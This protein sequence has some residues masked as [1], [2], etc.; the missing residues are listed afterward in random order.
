MKRWWPPGA[1]RWPRR[2]KEELGGSLPAPIGTGAG[3]RTAARPSGHPSCRRTS[4]RPQRAASCGSCVTS[5]SVAPCSRCRSNIRSITF[6]RG[7]VQAAGRLIGEQQVRVHH[8]AP[9]TRAAARRPTCAG[10]GAG[11]RPA[12]PARAWPGR[13]RA[14]W[15]ANSSGSMTFSS[16]VR[17]GSSWNDWNTKHIDWRA[18]ARP[19]L[20][21]GEQILAG[22]PHA[23]RA[24]NIQ[25]G[26]QSQQGGLAR[27]RAA[28]MARRCLPR[29]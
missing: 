3:V 13:P 7:R 1:R 27:A 17:F 23:A 14:G 2:S 12:P 10:N 29:P 18:A 5:T 24:G 9:A 4:W 25:P 6:A 22:Q 19:S 15:P 28:V 8:E 26:Q 11:A 20:V 21:Q 16:A